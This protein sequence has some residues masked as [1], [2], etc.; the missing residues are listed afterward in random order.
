MFIRY[1]I[2][3][4]D[5]AL[6]FSALFLCT[7]PGKSVKTSAALP[8]PFRVLPMW[9]PGALR[10]VYACTYTLQIGIPFDV[11]KSFRILEH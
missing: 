8:H 4:T 6:K 5:M 11:E 2:Q 7:F 9:I 3:V 10:P 1:L